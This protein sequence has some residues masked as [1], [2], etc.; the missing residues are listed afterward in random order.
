[1]SRKIIETKST[2]EIRSC[3]LCGILLSK[4]Y[5]KYMGVVDIVFR[6]YWEYE[7]VATVYNAD[8]CTKC[9][10]TKIIKVLKE[11]GVVLK[12]ELSGEEL[13]ERDLWQN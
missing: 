8:I 5:G 13:T 3:D 10:I 6:Q 7:S 12:N 9:F 4:D 11:N 1:M 2:I